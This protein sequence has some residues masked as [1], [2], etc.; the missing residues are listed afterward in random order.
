M[1]CTFQN[2]T[3][4][5]ANGWRKVRCSVCGFEFPLPTPSPLASIHH[6]CIATYVSAP[7]GRELSA[8]LTE[9][10]LSANASCGCAEFAAIMDE[11]G[12]DGCR[13]YRAEIIGRLKEGYESATWLETIRAGW[14]GLFQINPLDPLGSLVD[15]AIARTEAKLRLPVIGEQPI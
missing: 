3:K 6:R 12:I 8:V 11:W 9:F 13:E 15:L 2:S 5:D 4:P 7:V 14:R 10:R 1:N